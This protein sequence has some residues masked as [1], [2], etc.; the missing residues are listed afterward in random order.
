LAIAQADKPVAITLDIMLP[1][2]DG[3]EI[4]KRLKKD[5]VTNQIPA[6][7]V[8]VV[9]NPELGKALGAL[10]YLVKPFDAKELVKRLSQIN[11]KRIAPNGRTC[12]LVVDNEPANR[13]WLKQVLEPAGFEVAVA[14]TGQEA[15]ELARSHKPDVVMLDL[16][17]PDVDGLQLVNTLNDHTETKGIPIVVLTAK[18][19][20]TADM[21][22]L[23]G[24]VSS[25]LRRGTTGAIDL[26]GELQV[27]LNRGAVKV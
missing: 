15:I 4:L 6:I 14:S 1:D 17:K 8:S 16:M 13:D 24:R 12:V 26:I 3:W 11:L 20:S 7:V 9:D 18:H 25:I 27:I 23:D 10:D 21:E 22:Q 2:M 19:L 5:E